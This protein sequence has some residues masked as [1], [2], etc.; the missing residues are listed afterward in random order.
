M[1]QILKPADVAPRLLAGETLDAIFLDASGGYKSKLL[2]PQAEVSVGSEADRSVDFVIST[3]AVDRYTDIINLGGWK[4]QNY[5]R[6]PVVLWAHDDS[7]PAIGRGANVRVENKALR[8]TAVFATREVYPLADTIFQLIKGKFISAASVGFVPLKAKAASAK[9]RPYGIDI[10]EQE[11]LE[12]SVVNIPAN[13]ECLVNARAFGIDCAPLIGWAE[14][15][16]DKGGMLLIPR[17]ELEALRRAAGAPALHQVK[18]PAGPLKPAA[19]AEAAAKLKGARVRLDPAHQLNAPQGRWVKHLAHLS[20]AVGTVIESHIVAKGHRRGRHVLSVKWD[21]VC[22]S[23]DMRNV[24]ADRFLQ[25]EPAAAAPAPAR[26]IKSLSHV[27]WLAQLLNELGWLEDSVEWEAQLEEDGSDVP[28]RLLEAMKA[29]G[30]VLLDMTAEEVAELL[31]DDEAD[32]DDDELAGT[33]LPMAAALKSVRAVIAKA[34]KVLSA[35]NEKKLKTAHGHVKTAMDFCQ[36]AIAHVGD[37]IGQNDPN[38]DEGDEN[39]EASGADAAKQR[40]RVTHLRLSSSAAA[41]AA[42]QTA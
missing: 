27:A 24:A 30:Q 26:R 9:D 21:D 35:E 8:S 2:G 5:A 19:T 42:R 32:A 22:A 10:L 20:A 18:T 15:V 39:D 38:F 11:L 40:Q 3:E 25:V 14:R 37:V 17:D 36:K 41:I 31:D 16:L 7:I 33:I 34:G 29:L 28:A 23:D 13:P 12:W 6:N 4:T 1:P